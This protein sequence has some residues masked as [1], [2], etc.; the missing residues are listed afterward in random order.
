MEE[1]QCVLRAGWEDVFDWV[2]ERVRLFVPDAAGGRLLVHSTQPPPPPRQDFTSGKSQALTPGEKQNS[3]QSA[4]P[5]FRGRKLVLN[6]TDGSPCDS[7]SSKSKRAASPS[8]RNNDDDDEKHRRPKNPKGGSDRHK[9]NSPTQ[10]K[11]TLI[12][13]LCDR[14]PLAPQASVAFIGASPDECAYF[15]EVRSAAACGG[16]SDAR[17]SLGPGGVFGV[18]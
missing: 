6:Y 5:V 17:Q 12:S 4:S 11:S 18:M 16:V 13:L 3:Q 8:P 7:S 10:R 1:C 9:P 2:S 14:D 15:F